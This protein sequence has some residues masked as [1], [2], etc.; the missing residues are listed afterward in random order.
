MCDR[1]AISMHSIQQQSTGTSMKHIR[2]N[3]AQ[4]C[5]NTTWYSLCYPQQKRFFISDIS[6]NKVTGFETVDFT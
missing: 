3:Y 2:R 1:L 5:V 6:I 4:F